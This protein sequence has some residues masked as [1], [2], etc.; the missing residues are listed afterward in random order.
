MSYFQP[1][2][3]AMAGYVPGEQPGGGKFIKLNTNENPYP[4]SAK[5]T[6]AIKHAV[7][8]GL[9]RYPDPSA[10]A[11]R[12]RASELLKETVA[13]I[14]P[15]WIL[16]GNG[17]DDLLTIVTRALIDPGSIATTPTYLSSPIK[18]LAHPAI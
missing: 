16:C 11:F 3:T 13:G 14:G 5:V 1:N 18:H 8:A 12:V 6:A 17:S 15:D 7:Q 2:I 10:S 9:Q 4:C